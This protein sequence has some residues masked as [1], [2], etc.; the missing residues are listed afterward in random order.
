MMDMRTNYFRRQTTT[1]TWTG[2][3]LYNFRDD[4]V[5][6][7]YKI[8]SVILVF[9]FGFGFVLSEIVYIVLNLND[10]A[11]ITLTLGHF[12][13]HCSGEYC[14][15]ETK[16]KAKKKLQDWGNCLYFTIIEKPFDSVWSVWNETIFLIRSTRM[17]L[18]RLE[19]N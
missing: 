8:Y 17:W 4:N 13:A 1:L 2:V 16:K 12:F 19:G 7:A 15:E 10:V 18:Q 6:K 14:F 9:F 3:A 5:A 11:A